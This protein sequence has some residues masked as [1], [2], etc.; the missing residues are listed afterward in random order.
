MR[1]AEVWMDEYRYFL[2][3]RDAGPYSKIDPGD[4]TAQKAIREKLE[5]KPF[6]WFIENVAPDLIEMYPTIEPADYASGIIQNVEHPH[7]CIDL[8]N[9]MNNNSIGVWECAKNR[10]HPYSNQKFI[11]TAYKDIRNG[12]RNLCWD[13]AHA[14][15]GQPVHLNSCHRAKGNQ[16]WRYDYV[17]LK[18]CIR[19]A[20]DA[21]ANLLFIVFIFYLFK[22]IYFTAQEMD[23]ARKRRLL[24]SEFR[25]EKRD[26]IC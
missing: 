10:T 17:G 3:Q 24:V 12:D 7:Y 19:M 8:L 1:V 4:L 15:D 6:K 25:C 20:H 14:A 2:Y 18:F 9:L 22:F 16:L 13:L 5:C 26:C 11:L 21:R 23:N